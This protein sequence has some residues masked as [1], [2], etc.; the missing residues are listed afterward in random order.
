MIAYGLVVIYVML[1]VH[2][3]LGHALHSK[4]LKLIVNYI[5][6]DA[7]IQVLQQQLLLVPSIA[8]KK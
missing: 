1:K 4:E 3:L 5:D 7:Q 2:L 6:W 8:P